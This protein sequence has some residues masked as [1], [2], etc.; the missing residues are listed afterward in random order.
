MR[1][2]FIHDWL[3]GMRGGEKVL[4][5]LIDRYPQADI[6]TLFYEP[7]RISERIRRQHVTVSPLQRIPGARRHY[8]QLLPLFPWAIRRFDLRA[9]DL[10]ISI[11]HCVAKSAIAASPERHLCYCLSPMRYLWSH[12]DQYR[13]ARD[14]PL[15]TRLAMRW[16]REPLRRWDRATSRRAGAYVGISNTIAQ[17]IQ[18]A[19]GINAPV[20]YPPVDTE[21]FTPGPAGAEGYWLAVSASVP[22]KRLD[23]AIEA[24][25]RLRLPLKVAGGGPGV[26]RLRQMAGPTVEVLGWVSDERLR[27]LYRGCTGLVFPPEEDFGIAPVEAQACGKPVLAFGRGGA[28]ETVLNGIT[29]AFFEEQTGESLV[30]AM[31]TFDPTAYDPA[32]I[33]AHAEGF[34]IERFG[35][36]F[37]A[38]VERFLDGRPNAVKSSA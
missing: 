13:Q 17:R 33:R 1:V 9:Y 32:A 26:E 34:G 31:E 19:Y 28:R 3:N 36:E 5:A 15:A 16:L 11:S 10:V 29:G 7:E 37:V 27:D 22:Y 14:T 38:A 21:F 30:A 25:N 2:A 18:R 12:F 4:E 24:C 6:F 20:I 8:R 35:D 23:L